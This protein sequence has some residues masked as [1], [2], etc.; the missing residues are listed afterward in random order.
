MTT[1]ERLCTLYLI[2]QWPC[3][4]VI[5]MSTSAVM[6]MHLISQGCQYQDTSVIFL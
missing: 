2:T 4:Q 3:S 1:I 6:H 5:E